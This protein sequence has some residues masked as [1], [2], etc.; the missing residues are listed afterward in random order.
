[1]DGATVWVRAV[2]CNSPCGGTHLSVDGTKAQRIK[3][4]DPARRLAFKY[5][6]STRFDKLHR[7]LSSKKQHDPRTSHTVG[8]VR[9][10]KRDSVQTEFYGV[11]KIQV[12]SFGTAPRSPRAAPYKH[13]TGVSQKVAKRS[14]LVTHA[15]QATARRSE[16]LRRARVTFVVVCED[17]PR[18]TSARPTPPPRVGSTPSDLS[19]T[20]RIRPKTAS[21]AAPWQ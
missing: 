15:L 11:Q 14:A 18:T 4:V 20:N 19:F 12:S 3:R 21:A 13:P 5:G 2:Y 8:K 10:F 7:S 9:L 16:Q 1:M 6:A 17:T